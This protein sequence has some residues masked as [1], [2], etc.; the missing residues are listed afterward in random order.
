MLKVKPFRQTV[1]YCGPATLKMVLDYW[2]VNKT[3]KE[4]AMKLPKNITILYSDAKREYFPTEEIYKS[5]AEVKD[6]AQIIAGYIN[7]MGITTNLLPADDKLAVTLTKNS[8][9]MVIN[10]VDTI[11]GEEYLSSSVPALLE[12]LN[13]PYTGSGVMAFSISTNKFV[14]K[15]LLEQH[16]LS[17]PRYQLMNSYTDK[18]NPLLRYPFIS[19]LNAT[20]GSIEINDT[21]IS[22][23][24]KQL[25]DRVK[26][27]MSVYK[28]EVIVEE[29]IVGRE[30]TMIVF[31][32]TK[33]KVYPA[34]KIFSGFEGP[35]K[36]ATY[37]SVWGGDEKKTTQDYDSI[38]YE[39]GDELKKDIKKAYD[40][41]KMED[42]G[43]FDIRLDESGRYY[44][45]DPN[46]NNSFGP[47]EA[48]CAMGT[49]MDMYGIDFN[50]TLKRLITNTMSSVI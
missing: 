4:L 16:G 35:Y 1:G 39:L 29:F 24:E 17:V 46:V 41:L 10:L 38:K 7:K 40:V 33:R 12:L 44:I 25:R 11:R 36:L 23:N 3:E 42:Y 22:E 28:Q 48:D 21:A 26:H 14:T 2:G 9:D 32:G 43:K 45:I 27:L 34:E 49:I 50:E 8:P 18:I 13:I 15:K 19:K 47:K 20:H 37:D 31:E 5:E 30:L 6:R